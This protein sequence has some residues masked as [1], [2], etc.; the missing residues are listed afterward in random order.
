MP[1]MPG[2]RYRHRHAELSGAGSWHISLAMF[3]SA[4][5]ELCCLQD[6]QQ[7]RSNLQNAAAALQEELSQRQQVRLMPCC[8]SSALFSV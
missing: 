4:H 7:L 5:V 6:N 8:P 1:D 3:T 2:I